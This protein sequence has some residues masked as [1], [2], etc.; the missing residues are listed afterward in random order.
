MARACHPLDY[1][2]T[3]RYCEQGHFTCHPRICPSCISD[4]R[5][6]DRLESAEEVK[7]VRK[8]L[9]VSK[10]SEFQKWRIINREWVAA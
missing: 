8:Y 6:K 1:T 3:P 9:R 2:I 10:K 7:V 5:L 4:Q